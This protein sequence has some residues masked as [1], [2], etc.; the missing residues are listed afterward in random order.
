MNDG[1]FEFSENN[2]TVLSENAADIENFKLT[3][4]E[5]RLKKFEQEQK[6]ELANIEK[7]K[8]MSFKNQFYN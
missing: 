1:I 2:A 5:N 6:Q 3:E 8:L 7:N 4:L